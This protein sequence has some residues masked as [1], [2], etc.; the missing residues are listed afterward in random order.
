M[1]QPIISKILPHQSELLDMILTTPARR[2]HKS[3][4]LQDL[5]ET[6]YMRHKRFQGANRTV[7]GIFLVEKVKIFNPELYP[8]HGTLE[9]QPKWSLK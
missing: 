7:S 6:L 8:D 9:K 1:S 5:D 4:L 3:A 2:H